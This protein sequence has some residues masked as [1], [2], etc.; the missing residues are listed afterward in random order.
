MLSCWITLAPPPLPCALDD[1]DDA[2]ALR[3]GER[4][5]LHDA[6]RV[7]HLCTLVVVGRDLF[8]AHHLLAVEAVREA[9]HQRHRHRALHLVAHDDAGARFALPPLPPLRPL[10]LLLLPAHACLRSRRMVWSRAM[11]RRSVRSCSG[12]GIASVARR[13]ASRNRSSVRSTS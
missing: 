11:S 6:H 7:P 2:P 10:L 13:N 4:A 3:L 9:P 5:R 8:G 12:F 1:L